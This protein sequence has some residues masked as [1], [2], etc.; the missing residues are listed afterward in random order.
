VC[1][2]KFAIVT[3][4]SQRIGRNTDNK[5]QKKNAHALIYAKRNCILALYYNYYVFMNF[6][7]VTEVSVFFICIQIKFGTKEEKYTLPKQ[8]ALCVFKFSSLL[9]TLD[10]NNKAMKK[11]I[12]FFFES[13]LL[14]Y[15]IYLYNL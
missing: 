2:L 11:K 6:G 10:F 13:N 15:Y 3:V 12:L 9:F 8:A 7:F 1:V 14:S 5:I 4:A